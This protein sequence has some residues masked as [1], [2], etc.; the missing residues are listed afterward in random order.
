MIFK[1]YLMST[2]RW[3]QCRHV[4]LW[5]FKIRHVIGL[6]DM[7]RAS[8]LQVSVSDMCPTRT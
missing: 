2:R 3:T 5:L 7:C 6:F 4:I 1:F 8:V